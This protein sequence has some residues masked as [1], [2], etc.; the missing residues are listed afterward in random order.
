MSDKIKPIEP[1]SS[2]S[3]IQPESTNRPKTDDFRK[4]IQEEMEKRLRCKKAKRKKKG[5]SSKG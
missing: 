2:V 3:P 1:L 5:L 4:K